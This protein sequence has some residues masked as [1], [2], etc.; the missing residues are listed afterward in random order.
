MKPRLARLSSRQ[1]A[2]DGEA[3]SG[4]QH[5]GQIVDQVVH[6]LDANRQPGE[7]IRDADMQTGCHGF[8]ADTARLPLLCAG[9]YT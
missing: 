1:A 8:A 5:L 7:R 4:G 2:T 6:V 3:C 9:C